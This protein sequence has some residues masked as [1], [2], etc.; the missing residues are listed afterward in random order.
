MTLLFYPWWPAAAA[1][2]LAGA[3][4]WTAPRDAEHPPRWPLELALALACGLWVALAG[5]QWLVRFALVGTTW[6][7]SDFYEY[8]AATDALRQGDPAAF[9]AQRSALAAWPGAWWA[10]LH[11]IVDGLAF[12]ATLSAGLLGAA[13]YGWGRALAGPTAGLGAALLAPALTPLVL[14][15]R[16]LSL[17]PQSTALFALGAAGAALALR[18]SRPAGLLAGGAGTGLCFLADPRGLFWGLAFLGLSGLAAVWAPPRRW[19]LNLTLVLL[20]VLLSWKAGEVVYQAAFPLETVM[21]LHMRMQERGIFQTALRPPHAAP[22]EYIW[23]RTDPR[24]IPTTVRFLVEESGQVPPA[25][26]Q[27]RE[28]RDNVADFVTPLAGGVLVCAGLGLLNLLRGPARLRRLAALVGT[29]VPFAAAFSGAVKV[30]YARPHYLANAW[31]LVAVL[32]GL[33]LAALLDGAPWPPSRAGRWWTPARVVGGAALGVALA[34]GGLPTPLSPRWEGRDPLPR[35]DQ[36]LLSAL[37][38]ANTGDTAGL[39]EMRTRCV[40]ALQADLAQGL[41]PGG[42]LYGGVDAAAQ[43]GAGGQPP[44]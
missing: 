4:A 14:L 43:S 2:L 44:R 25:S 41:A 36:D 26:W 28:T 3:C 20:P 38:R 39:D 29:A 17:Y 23:G 24:D 40:Q 42:T 9:S 11:G 18:S 16:T 7:C 6:S 1:A 21:N 27:N 31:P 35:S 32:L 33:G 34:L 37:R 8:C 19:P 30:Q 15:P 10:R 12:G 5:G 13:L 22:A